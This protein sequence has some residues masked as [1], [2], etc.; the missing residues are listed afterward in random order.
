MQ[1]K[2]WTR[3]FETNDGVITDQ[4]RTVVTELKYKNIQ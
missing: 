1:K 3:P 2:T 4:M